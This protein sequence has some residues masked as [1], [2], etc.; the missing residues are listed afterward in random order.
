MPLLYEYNIYIYISMPLLYVYHLIL[1][2]S[3]FFTFLIL[4]ATEAMHA[5]GFI[6]HGN[7]LRSE[8]SISEQRMA[9]LKEIKKCLS[10][11][12]EVCN[13]EFDSLPLRHATD[14]K[15]TSVLGAGAHS[16]IGRRAD[17]EDDDLIVDNFGNIPTTGFF[18]LYDGHGG[19]QT[20]DFVVKTLH[21]NFAQAF[22]QKKDLPLEDVFKIA[23]LSTDSQL[24]RRGITRSGSTA[25]TCLLQ[26][27]EGKRV[28]HSANVGD[29]RA[30]LCR[31]GR[32]VRLT[33]DHK[34]TLPEEAK[35][36]KD[37]G[38]YIGRNQR[39]NGILAISRALGDHMLKDK[40]N[41][42]SAEPYCKSVELIEED[43][44]LILACDGVWDVMTDQDAV[45]FLL[46]T[47]RKHQEDAVKHGLE[48]DQNR[49]LTIC[50]QGLV[51]L[52][53]QKRTLDNVSVICIKLR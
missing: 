44:F 52:A 10:Q 25:V 50:S 30:I 8:D 7:F 45:D 24:R 2:F 23:Y 41:I 43:E 40:N 21:L 42:V 15:F 35:R 4:G 6:K 18:A 31:G 17:M 37:A 49:V 29:S 48:V 9:D 34:A 11:R 33:I 3:L 12:L 46:T 32:A 16:D 22:E 53:L 19:R 28:L 36:V 26:Q 13:K 51:Q 1:L 39:V 27:E 5:I 14:H 38:G 47:Y 20:V